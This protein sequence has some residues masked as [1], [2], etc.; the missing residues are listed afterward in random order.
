M[1]NLLADDQLKKFSSSVLHNWLASFIS[2]L[3]NESTVSSAKSM[4]TNLLDMLGKSLIKNKNSRGPKIE[5]WGT[6]LRM[7]RHGDDTP[8]ILTD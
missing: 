3:R 6:P 7:G 1:L 8:F 4:G 2:E 5:P